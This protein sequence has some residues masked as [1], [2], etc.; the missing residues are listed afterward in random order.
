[1]PRVKRGTVRRAKR[2]KL[3]TRA[4]GFFQTKSKLYAFTKEAV[5][6]ALIRL[7]RPPPKKRD[8]RRLWIV[9][10]NAAAREHGL[11]YSAF[12]NGLK[13]AGVE[14]DRKMLAELAVT[15]AAAFAALAAKAQAAAR[16]LEPAPG[17][18]AWS[19]DERSREPP[20]D[21]AHSGSCVA[22]VADHAGD[23][24]RRLGRR[25]P[26][27]AGVVRRRSEALTIA[28]SAGSRG[29]RLADAAG[30]IWPSLPPADAP[31]ARCGW[32]TS[33]S[34]ASRRRST[35]REAA[36][37][38]TGGRRP[39]PSTSTLPGRAPPLGHRHP[40]TLLRERIECIF[41]RSATRSSTAPRPRT[42]STTSRRSTCRPSILPATCRTR[43]IWR[44]P[45]IHRRRQSR[46]AIAEREAGAAAATLLRTHTS[47][48][49]IRY[50]ERHEPPVRIMAPGPRLSPRQPRPDAHADVPPGRGAGRRRAHHDG[51]P[52]GNAAGVRR[53]LFGAGHAMCFRPSF[54]PYTEPSAEVDIGCIAAAAP[55]ARCASAPAGSRSSAAA[56]SIRRCSKR[57]ATTP[58]GT[59]ASPS[60]WASSAWRCC[61]YGVDDIRL[62]YEND[63]RF[64]EQF[65]SEVLVSW[66]RDFV[67]VPGGPA[68]L[69][70]ATLHGSRG[71][72]VAAGRAG[73]PAM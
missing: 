65:G 42:T 32:P 13:A 55:A 59:P 36:S 26:R 67:D 66:L 45:C 71:F 72:E 19:R 2:K 40:L 47:A 39:A 22:S 10:I 14:L 12:I 17:D 8:F 7:C 58:S 33:S 56:W 34:R 38:A 48:M 35:E 1:M 49:Q 11:S 3:L 69:G 24:R 6:K 27:G 5:D 18:S 25:R 30:P 43:S 68:E 73:A 64:L 63:L 21:G 54:F 20:S 15:R 70:R 31:R 61:K 16:S 4:K 62:F 52:E 57:S 28:T 37:A 53:A 41:A 60:A 23:V 46:R 44:R 51:R 50:M 9:R 29:G